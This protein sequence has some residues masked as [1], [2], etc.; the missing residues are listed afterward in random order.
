MRTAGSGQPALP[1]KS[2]VGRGAELDETRFSA[3]PTAPPPLLQYK[4]CSDSTSHAIGSKPT[5]Q[6]GYRIPP[7]PSPKQHGAGLSPERA[8]QD[9]RPVRLRLAPPGAERYAQVCCH[10]EHSEESLSF[11]LVSHLEQKKEILHFVQNDSY[12]H[13]YA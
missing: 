5:I 6:S 2:E 13:R 8:R 4:L 3:I 11:W 1:E 9:H 10:S 12:L 7:H